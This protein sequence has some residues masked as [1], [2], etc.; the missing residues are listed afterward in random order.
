MLLYIQYSVFENTSYGKSGAA[1]GCLLRGV[2]GGGG[3]KI[4]KM[5]EPKKFA[6]A[7][8]FF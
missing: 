3:G 4:T 8:N 1:P 6:P 2:G 5:C 7:L